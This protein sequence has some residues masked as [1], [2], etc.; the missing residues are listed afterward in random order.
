M[1]TSPPVRPASLGI[2]L[3]LAACVS[4]PGIGQSTYDTAPR[5]TSAERGPAPRTNGPITRDEVEA[6]TQTDAY[7]LIYKARPGW[8]RARSPVGIGVNGV[9]PIQAFVDGM[10][11]GPAEYLKQVPISVIESVIFLNGM[12]ATQRFGTDHGNGAILVTTRS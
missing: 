8:L 3:L 1:R 12:E 9:A 5:G 10:P 11:V 4:Q 6:S 2:V 7:R